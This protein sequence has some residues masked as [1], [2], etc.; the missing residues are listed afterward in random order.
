[1]KINYIVAPRQV[2]KTRAVLY[3]FVKDPGNTYFF[4]KYI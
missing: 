2:G 1:M 4:H 3:E